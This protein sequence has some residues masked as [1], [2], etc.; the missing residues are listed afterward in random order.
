LLRAHGASP[1]ATTD[2]GTAPVAV[3][4]GLARDLAEGRSAIPDC[5]DRLHRPGG[6]LEP[7]ADWLA[8]RDISPAAAAALLARLARMVGPQIAAGRDQPLQHGM[9]ATDAVLA[10]LEHYDARA[11]GSQDV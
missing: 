4:L 8:I 5:V 2:T 10:V 11:L 7:F 3:V 9:R 6:P 1:S